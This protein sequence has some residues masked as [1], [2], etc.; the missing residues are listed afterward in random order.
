MRTAD[1]QSLIALIE[2]DLGTLN[3]KA[4]LLLGEVLQMGNRI[5]PLQFAAKLQVSAC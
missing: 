1:V 4:T 2:E 3:R 5:L